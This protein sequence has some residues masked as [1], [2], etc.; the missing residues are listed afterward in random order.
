M[1]E[2][3]T[4]TVENRDWELAN[5]YVNLTPGNKTEA[6]RVFCATHNNKV[7]PEFINRYAHQAFKKPSVQKYVEQLRAENRALYADMRDN[8]IANLA[9]M[10]TDL[11][12]KKSDRIAA[13]KELNSMF[14]YNQQNINMDATQTI[15]VSLV[16]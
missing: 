12:T 1:S 8:N 14:G 6:Y 11:D 4:E 9:S 13:I 16:D 10:A 2:A 7:K 15:N 3:S 5:L